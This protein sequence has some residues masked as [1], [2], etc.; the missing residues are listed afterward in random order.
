MNKKTL[1]FFLFLGS[2]LQAADPATP[3]S[4]NS[5]GN[6]FEQIP[7]LYEWAI[8]EAKLLVCN[9]ALLLQRNQ[10][11]KQHDIKNLQTDVERFIKIVKRFQAQSRPF[12][13]EQK[14]NFLHII[15]KSNNNLLANNKHLI[16][17]FEHKKEPS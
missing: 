4:L 12:T 16:Q 9:H 14:N 5:T 11:T 1:F 6:N 3:R 7:C 15:R 2:F 17:E 13:P 8:T 10:Y